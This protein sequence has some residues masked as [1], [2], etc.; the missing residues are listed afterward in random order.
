MNLPMM[1]EVVMMRMKVSLE[2]EMVLR[3]RW[4]MAVMIGLT[5]IAAM[6]RVGIVQQV[7]S[8]W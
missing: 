3:K 4:R 6:R 5:V 7:Q 8:W 1:I 2:A